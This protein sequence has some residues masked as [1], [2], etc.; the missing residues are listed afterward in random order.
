[1]ESS[2]TLFPLLAICTPIYEEA[3]DWIKFDYTGDWT[4]NYMAP[5]STVLV[6]FMVW[7]GDPL[8][9]PTLLHLRRSYPRA[10]DPLP[11]STTPTPPSPDY[12]NYYLIGWATKLRD[13]DPVMEGGDRGAIYNPNLGMMNN[14]SPIVGNIATTNKLIP[15]LAKVPLDIHPTGQ[16]PEHREPYSP[17]YCEC[18]GG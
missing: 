11:T 7:Q 14:L 4:G 8:F 15:R 12:T 3:L 13:S 6:R 10:Y 17:P 16:A 5:S 1:M 18:G 2:H 9:Y